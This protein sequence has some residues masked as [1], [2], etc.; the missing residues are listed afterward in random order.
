MKKSLL[1]LAAVAALCANAEVVELPISGGW[2]TSA[3]TSGSMTINFA[4]QW[5]EF[6]L[7]N[8]AID[9]TVYKS[10]TLEYEVLAGEFQF[11]VEDGIEDEGDYPEIPADETTIT[12][13][14]S[15]Y[16]ANISV[17]EIQAKEAN[18]SI[19]LKSVSLN[20]KEGDPVAPTYGGPAWGCNSTDVIFT[21]KW[22]ELGG[23]GWAVTLEEGETVTYTVELN[24][25]CPADIQ[26]KA[27]GPEKD[28]YYLPIEEG[29]TKATYTSEISLT[30]LTLQYIGE[31]PPS[32]TLSVKSVSYE[33]KAATDG[34]SSVAAEGVAPVY[35]N[36]QGVQV[37]NPERGIFIQ[38]VGNKATKVI[39]N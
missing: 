29:A 4:S 34:I 9:I 39:L 12:V 30:S 3:P 8:E 14:F 11:K 20:P 10:A 16:T 26:F 24:S 33:I 27:I 31:N 1:A 37:A 17:F 7:V 35:Y 25:G 38:R 23:S 13:D 36:L 5:G 32:G 21:S 15:N 2:G 18:S 6:K 19:Y 22:A 28:E